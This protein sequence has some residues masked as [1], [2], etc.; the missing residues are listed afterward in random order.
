MKFVKF[1]SHRARDY[2][3]RE[4]ERKPTSFFSTQRETGTGGVYEVTEAEIVAM[5]NGSRH[6]RFTILRP[7][8][9]DLMECWKI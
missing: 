9:D 2:A 1:T 4:L 5:R 7:P 8:Y 3:L 6:A